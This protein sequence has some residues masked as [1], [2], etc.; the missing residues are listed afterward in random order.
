MST[1]IALVGDPTVIC[2]DEPTS[3]M[4]AKARRLLWNDILSLIKENRIVLL[5]SHTMEECEAL[6][7]RLVIMVNGKFKCIGSP[8]HLKQKFGDGFMLRIRLKDES[9]REILINFMH[10]NFPDAKVQDSHRDLFEYVLPFSTTKLSKLF[11][12]LEKHRDAPLGI[13]DYSI[14]QSTLD[15][16]FIRFAREQKQDAFGKEEK[17]EIKEKEFTDLVQNAPPAAEHE[18]EAIDEWESTRF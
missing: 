4:D 11:E 5:T 2:L 18:L 12:K 13:L 15:Q 1:A 6:C 7:T 8:Q 3:G 17:V 16:I 14:N 10:E 9:T